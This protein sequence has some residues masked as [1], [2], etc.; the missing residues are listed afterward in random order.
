MIRFAFLGT[1]EFAAVILEKIIA[2]GFLPAIVVT[3]P[4]RPVGRKKIVTAP[5][6]KRV[7]LR[8]GIRVWQPE[9]LEIGNWKLEIGEIDIAVV[10]AYA[11]I[12]PKEIVDAPRLGTIGVHPS[13][14]PKYR[15]ATPIQ[16]A[17]LAGEIETGVTLYLMDEKVDHGGIISNIKVQ[18]SNLD[19]YDTLEKKLAERAGDLLSEALPKFI[20]S[21]INA[22]PQN[23]K[24]ATFTKKFKTE[25]GYIPVET[26]KEALSGSTEKVAMLDRKIRSLGGEPGVY[27][28]IGGKRLKLLA[29][30]LRDG[31]ITITRIQFAGEN[32]KPVAWLKLPYA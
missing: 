17:I 28:E 5:P 10:A 22:D 3:N 8:H 16:S 29:V 15:G 6:A 24:E 2:R 11:K 23:E 18:I 9:R 19:T 32:P 14:L 26:I 20:E 30:S 4:D 21:K 7:A 1:P 25:D 12:L 27:T 13:L 31:R